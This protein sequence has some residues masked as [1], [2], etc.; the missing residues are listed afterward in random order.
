M[1]ANS[2][3]SLLR[4]ALALCI[5]VGLTAGAARA[6]QGVTKNTIRIGMFGPLTGAVSMYG[7]PINDG[8]IAVYKHI[9]DEG[10][11]YGRKIQIVQEDGACNPVKTRAAVKKLLDE[12]NVFMVNGGTC[13]AAVYAAKS[14][15]IRDKVPLMV[16]AATDDR[17]SVPVNPYIFTTTLTGSKD[18]KAMLRFAESDPHVERLAVVQHDDDWAASRMDAIKAGLKSSKIKLVADVTLNRGASDATAQVLKIKQSHP[19]MIF[20]ITYPAES[21]VFL[22]DAHNYG[23]TGPFVGPVSIMDM[24]DLA[25]RA[26]GLD[27]VKN[28]YVDAFLKAP[29]DDPV[30]KPYTD[31]VKK[32]FPNIKL[33]SLNFYGMSSAFAVV[34]ALKAA[35]PDLT[36]AKFRHALNHLK[37]VD[38]GPAYCKIT[39]TPQDH[40]G[41]HNAHMWTIKDGKIV[42][43]G[44][45]WPRSK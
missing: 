44:P 20:M 28:T 26:G 40:Q 12:D 16:M 14:E 36:R 37:N 35:G 6:E 31:L 19:D 29:I 43:V 7:Y 1:C 13:S 33:Q 30:T 32:Y 4:F 38:A 34:A 15:F 17:I 2:L 8:A 45:T 18:G 22:R 42:V 41:C 10:G 27:V 3:R 21:A 9:N 24:L 11:I 39:F 5:G 25:H 23:L